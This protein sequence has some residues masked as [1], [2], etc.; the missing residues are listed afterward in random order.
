MVNG[1]ALVKQYGPLAGRALLALI[2][3][4]AGYG[5]IGSFAQTAGYMASKGLPMAEVLLVATIAI[6]LGGG[7]MILAGWHARWAAL[8]IF[9]FIIPTTLVFH[10]F[11]AVDAAQKG[12]Q[13]NHFLK[14]LAIMG[15]MLYVMA[16]GPGPTS[17]QKGRDV[18]DGSKSR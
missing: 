9:L 2:F 7:L 1:C 14:N 6:E 13:M 10:P 4:I 5:K 17:L 11:W 18:P 16:Y 12:N 15:G 3:I 8:A